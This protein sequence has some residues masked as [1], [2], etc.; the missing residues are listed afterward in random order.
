MLESHRVN[1]E[2]HRAEARP[3]DFPRTHVRAR[4]NKTALT[5][6]LTK[7]FS[8]RLNIATL[9]QLPC[10]HVWETKKIINALAE[11]LKKVSRQSVYFT[12]CG[13]IPENDA[14]IMG[15]VFPHPGPET[16]LISSDDFGKRFGKPRRK[17]TG[18][19]G[20]KIIR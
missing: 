9:R 13:G 18:K 2:P 16:I 7:G 6:K 19:K 10:V 5:V 8:R 17:T 15:N 12:L 4:E 3:A 20:T 11:I 1:P 14:E